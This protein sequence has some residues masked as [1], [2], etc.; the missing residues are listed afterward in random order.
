M[1]IARKSRF[2]PT[3]R[4]LLDDLWRKTC[5]LMPYKRPGEE[6]ASFCES[7]VDELEDKVK[8]LKQWADHQH[9]T[10]GVYPDAEVSEFLNGPE[11]NQ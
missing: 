6:P 10:T 8:S 5:L 1:S 11:L 9:A 4:E 7:V 3:H 2:E